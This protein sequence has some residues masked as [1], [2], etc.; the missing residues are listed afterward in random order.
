MTDNPWKTKAVQTVYENPWIRLEQH[1]IINPAGKDGV[2]GKVHFK[3]KAMA[4]IPIDEEGYTWLV[5][6]F[7]YTLDA[8]SWEIPM[9][10]GPIELDLLESAKRELKEETGLIA[11]KWTE[12]LK[13]HTSNSVTD[14]EGIV[15]LAEGL[16]EGETEFEETEVL[17]VK[18]IPF[19][20]V[21]EMV[22]TGEITDSISIA[23]ILKVARILGY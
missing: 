20:E 14:E 12:V 8:Y 18:R 2:Y 11:E 16:T 17:Q 6:Q 1:D 9:G 23:G 21:V 5:G 22:M 19:K 15:Y 7:R 4:I 13:I 10:G 3:N